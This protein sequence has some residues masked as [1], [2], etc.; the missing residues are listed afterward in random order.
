VVFSFLIA[1]VENGTEKFF[2]EVVH[3]A[4]LLVVAEG[5]MPDCWL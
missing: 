5:S 4:Q 2:Q 1:L 3:L